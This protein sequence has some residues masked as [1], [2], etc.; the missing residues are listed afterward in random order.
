MVQNQPPDQIKQPHSRTSKKSH[1]NLDHFT[2]LQDVKEVDLNAKNLETDETIQTAGDLENANPLIGMKHQ[3][4]ITDPLHALTQ[5]TFSQPLPHKNQDH[6]TGA[7]K[8]IH[9]SERIPE[10]NRVP[11]KFSHEQKTDS[12]NTSE[13]I[14]H[15]HTHEM[16]EPP[17]TNSPNTFAPNLQNIDVEKGEIPH[18]Q[19]TLTADDNFKNNTQYA[20]QTNY[21]PNPSETHTDINPA[22]T[23]HLSP[24]TIKKTPENH[25]KGKE[26]RNKYN[27]ADSNSLDSDHDRG[28]GNDPD[29][30]DEDNPALYKKHQSSDEN[31]KTP[32]FE[33]KDLDQIHHD[34]N[35]HHD[36]FNFHQNSSHS[37]SQ[38]SWLDTIDNKNEHL[39]HTTMNNNDTHTSW[40]ENID[41][42]HE[43]NSHNTSAP[44]EDPHHDTLSNTHTNTDHNNSDPT[45]GTS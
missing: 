36:F 13:H 6:Q 43:N 45:S 41:T 17:Q 12:E 27:K 29:K 35:P 33:F 28:H 25:S 30:I 2:V 4:N 9:N 34:N 31:N 42:Q 18:S 8:P 5:N 37:N 11:E 20:S 44:N 24:D 14:S 1:V 10:Q 39:N 19:T 15:N 21:T 38:T 7:P 16:Q 22:E 23:A 3:E 40:L 32:E 26:E